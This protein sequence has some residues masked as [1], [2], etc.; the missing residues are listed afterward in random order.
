MQLIIYFYN[1]DVVNVSVINN[2]VRLV[3]TLYST[4]FK[5]KNW[6]NPKFTHK[7]LNGIPVN[8]NISIY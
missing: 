5:Y 3:V 6:L 7:I 4:L 1:Y 2:R 8:P